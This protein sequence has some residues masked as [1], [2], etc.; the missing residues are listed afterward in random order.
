M[1]LTYVFCLLRSG[2]RPALGRVPATMPGG[3]PVRTLQA[4]PD[5]WLIVATVPVS[6][7]GEEALETGL[8][9]LDWVGRHALAH[10]SVVEHFLSA[11]AV[12][13]MQLF[14]LFTSDER[15][16]AH[17]TRNRKRI[18][19]AL[20]RV[21]RHQEWGL[22]LTADADAPAA[23]SPKP[24]LPQP[25]TGA[26]YLVRKR[27]LLDEQRQRLV[28]ARSEGTRVYRTMAR[29]ATAARRRTATEQASTGS[30]LVLDAAFLVATGRSAAF[31]TALRRE[32]KRLGPTGVQVV[33]TGPWPPYNFV[34]APGRARRA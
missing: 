6:R 18:E 16:L 5:T 3:E 27:D 31:K 4:A 20:S 1:T 33:M 11:R 2:R 10:E 8:R 21:E 12:L 34:G 28:R 26:A 19:A 29:E 7:Y 25:R 30:K 22:R 24:R 17:V 15:V 32:A 13:P 23:A 14:T 9:N